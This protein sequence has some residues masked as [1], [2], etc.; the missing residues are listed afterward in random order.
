MKFMKKVIV[1]FALGLLASLCYTQCYGQD[2]EQRI[3]TLRPSKELIQIHHAL[4]K[5][6]ATIFNPEV[7]NHPLIVLDTD[8]I[9]AFTDGKNICI[10]KGFIDF[11]SKPEEIATIL[12]HEM[13]H[14]FL[15]HLRIVPVKKYEVEA[16]YVGLYIMAKAGFSIDNAANIWRKF[17]V[18]FPSKISNNQFFASHPGSA[19]R[20]VILKKTIE[21]IK[22]KKRKSLQLFPE[23][24]S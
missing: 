16:D 1:F 3:R 19:E 10:S 23:G 2:K 6:A 8:K 22:R 4:L 14:I 17:A 24:L 15:K 20:Y 5:S 7:K 9:I 11:A 21:E 18:K 13:S 12:S